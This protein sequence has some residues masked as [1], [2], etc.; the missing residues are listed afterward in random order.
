MRRLLIV[1]LA[2]AA[3]MAGAAPVPA[4]AATPLDFRRCAGAGFSCAHMSVPLDRSG[5]VPGRV[6]LFVKRIRATAKRRRGVLVALAGGPGQSATAAFDGD[7]LDIVA[8]ALRRRDLIVYDQRGSGR[9][10]LLRC[11]GLERVNL[12]RAGAQ[13]ARC[14]KH[15]GRR[16]GFYASRD[17]ADDLEALRRRLGVPKL[18]L[19]G[20]S[21]GTR[22]ALAY[23][24]RHPS[25]VDRLVLD[26]VVEPDGPDA[27]YRSTFA[28][29][30]RALEAVCRRGCRA[31]TQ[32]PVADLRA[33]VERLSRGRLAGHVVDAQGRRRR[34]TLDRFDLLLVLVA[35]DFDRRLRAA[36]PGAVRAA[37]DGDPAPLLRMRTRAY[38]LEGGPTEPRLLSPALYAATSCEEAMLPW[39][40]G[41]TFAERPGQA[42]ATAAMVPDTVFAP[43]DRATALRSDF[44]DLCGRWPESARSPVPGPG[45]LPDVPT[46]LIEGEDDLRTPVESARI[47]QRALPRSQLL[48]VPGVGHSVASVDA[49]GCVVNVIGRFL[50]GGRGPRRCRGRRRL[51]APPPP[52]ASLRSVRPLPGSAGA[53]GRALAGVRLTLADVADGLRASLA[54]DDRGAT[55]G[56]GLRRGRYALAGSG[57]LRLRDVSLIPGLRVSGRIEEFGVDLDRRRV[58]R[59]LRGRERGVLRIEGPRGTS[60]TL[61]VFYADRFRGRLGGRRMSG[62]FGA[63]ARFLRA[64]PTDAPR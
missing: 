6:S 49:S 62:R 11:L 20:V 52:P 63:G 19:Y 32:S 33:L 35:G 43:F 17:S 25:R 60:G 14:A 27:L 31:F 30:P 64:G 1:V 12:L 57:V 50:N 5:Q 47:V 23:A 59:G 24:L 22:T 16:R 58:P 41:A 9:S 8:P 15:L 10:G 21:Y 28:A 37:L 36:F 56:G 46:L 51:S 45:P 38:E 2:G 44:I 40:R 29:V 4:A 7:A 3:A 26:S 48:I 34:R 39:Q 18:S 53:R 42:A 54:F 13:A 61:R 55:L